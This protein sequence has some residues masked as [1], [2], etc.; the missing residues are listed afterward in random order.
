MRCVA[1]ETLARRGEL[2][3]LEVCDI[4]FHPNGTDQAII[5]RGKRMRKGREG[6]RTYGGK[7]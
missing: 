3:A 1:Y 5:P 2:V 4:D 7:L 6:W